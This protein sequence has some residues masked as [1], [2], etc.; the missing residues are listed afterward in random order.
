M[1]KVDPS[2]LWSK[3]VSSSHWITGTKCEATF[4]MLTQAN[5]EFVADAVTSVLVPEAKQIGTTELVAHWVF[6]DGVLRVYGY[7]RGSMSRSTDAWLSGRLTRRMRDGAGKAYDGRVLTST[8]ASAVSGQR[9]TSMLLSF[10]MRYESHWV[11]AVTAKFKAVG[12][13]ADGVQWPGT[14]RLVLAN[15]FGSRRPKR[16]S[17]GGGSKMASDVRYSRIR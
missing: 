4:W 8:A 13:Y 6:R 17:S 9:N 12:L 7:I 10:S 1:G 2:G 16:S 14:V 5:R 15:P 3:R 11:R